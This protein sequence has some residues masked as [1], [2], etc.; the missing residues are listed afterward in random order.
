M[1][2]RWD[3]QKFPPDILITNYSMLNIMLMRNIEADIFEKT[4]QWLQQDRINHKFQLVLDELHTYRG[5][6]GTEIAYLLRTFLDRI[7]LTP[8]SNQLQILASSASLGDN[9]EESKQFLKEFFGCKDKDKFEII[10]GDLITPDDCNGIEKDLKSLFYDKTKKKYL[11]KSL[12]E[13]KK[14]VEKHL[15]NWKIYLKKITFH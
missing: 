10:S 14:T 2:S 9:E 13:L 11:T 3:M 6:A 7:G 15:K 5:T 4:K 1:Y 8:D 12:N